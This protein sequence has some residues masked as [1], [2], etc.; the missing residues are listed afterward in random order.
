MA[1]LTLKGVVSDIEAD[2]GEALIFLTKEGT[3]LAQGGP[4]GLAALAVLLGAVDKELADAQS[5]NVAAAIADIKPVWPDV[6]ALAADLGIK[7]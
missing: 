1:K 7:L 3:K 2:A 4:R 5:G 6:K